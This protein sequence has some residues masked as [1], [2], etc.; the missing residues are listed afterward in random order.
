MSENYCDYHDGK[1]PDC[2]MCWTQN[3]NAPS[4]LAAPICSAPD[5]RIEWHIKECRRRYGTEV[6]ELAVKLALAAHERGDNDEA[7]DWEAHNAM[8]FQ[9][10]LE[11]N[12]KLSDSPAGSLPKT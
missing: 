12:A 3:L 9:V 6:T 1:N 5:P 8:S 4:S 2:Q 11:L 10:V 7:H